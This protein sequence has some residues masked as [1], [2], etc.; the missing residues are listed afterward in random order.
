MTRAILLFAACSALLSLVGCALFHTPTDIRIL[1]EEYPPLNFT[2]N[3]SP[4]GLAVDVVNALLA[5]MHQTGAI[6]VMGWETAY[7]LA[8]AGPKT[9]IFSMAL[10]AERK[11]LF[12]WVGPLATLET[13][14]YAAANSVLTITSLE[15]ARAVG[16]IVT[17][18]DYYTEQMLRDAGFT[19]LAVCDNEDIAIRKLLAGEADLFPSNNLAIGPLLEKRHL[20]KRHHERLSNLHGPCLRRLLPGYAGTDRTAVAGRAR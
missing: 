4:A 5:R 16:R 3:G 20:R 13:R 2:R 7:G 8:Q 14:F 6:E 18:R 15:E 1:T 12:Q 17:V 9:A 19:N 11:D 10:N